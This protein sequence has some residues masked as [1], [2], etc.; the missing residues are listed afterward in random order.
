MIEKPS[1]QR[2]ACTVHATA[3]VLASSATSLPVELAEKDAAVAMRDAAA[4]PAA[5]DDVDG[6]LEVGAVRPKDRARRDVEREEIAGAGRHVNDAV[7]DER[8]RFAGILRP[9][10]GAARDRVRHT[11]LRFATLLRSICVSGE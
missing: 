2:S 5:A 4:R 11:P 3:P 8:L 7:D 1:C 6:G 9:D 10:A